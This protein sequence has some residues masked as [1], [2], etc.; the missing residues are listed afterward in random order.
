MN[1][2]KNLFKTDFISEAREILD[3]LD[4]IAI[5]T[6]AT[7]FSDDNGNVLENATIEQLGVAK[8]KST[9]DTTVFTNA[10][11]NAEVV[12][13]RIDELRAQIENTKDDYLKTKLKRRLAKLTGG[14]AVVRVGAATEVELKEKKFRVED[15]IAATRAALEEGIV[16]GGGIAL[17]N[18]SKGLDIPDGTDDYLRG[19][20]ILLESVSE[21]LKQIAENAGV[22]GEVVLNK[23]YE[24]D[25]DGY[26]YNAATEEYCDMMSAGIIDTT[27]AIKNALLN[28][29]SVA[30]MILT[31]ECTITDIPK[32]DKEPMIMSPV[33]PMPL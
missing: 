13:A 19:V 12:R 17:I 30:G 25:S 31:T 11:G 10:K 4:D 28:A 22:N 15:T 16:P 6:G 9:K 21:P 33:G 8:V 5:L 3:S 14:V 20:D 29:A 7:L 1:I 18:A 24:H 32:K 26:G 2:D 27:K 23:I